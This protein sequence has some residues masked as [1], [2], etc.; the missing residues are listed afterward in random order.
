MP[1]V[2]LIRHVNINYTQS[3]NVPL[4]EFIYL[5]FIH[6]KHSQHIQVRVTGGGSGH[7]Y[8]VFC[9]S[10][11]VCWLQ[12]I[13]P[14]PLFLFVCFLL[15]LHSRIPASYS[16]SKFTN[17]TFLLHHPV[18]WSM[19][20]PSVMFF[21]VR[22]PSN[23]QMVYKICQHEGWQVNFLLLLFLAPPPPLFSVLSNLWARFRGTAPMLLIPVLLYACPTWGQFHILPKV[24]RRYVRLS[25]GHPLQRRQALLARH[26]SDACSDSMYVKYHLWHP[27]Q[28]YLLPTAEFEET[29][30]S[31]N[32][33]KSWVKNQGI[34]LSLNNSLSLGAKFKKALMPKYF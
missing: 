27:L 1:K 3:E 18:M 21:D 7:C 5:V 14:H 26:F 11:D 24:H 34:W 19:R 32:T 33:C 4:V 12:L 31:L 15:K 8:C 2:T 25:L 9:H 20:S 28:C 17:Y 29:G 30:V 23:W 10:C 6:T 16:Q 22:Q 13:P